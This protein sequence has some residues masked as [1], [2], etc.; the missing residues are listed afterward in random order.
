MSIDVPSAYGYPD[1]ALYEEG[2]PGSTHLR[3]VARQ[4][5]DRL[6]GR[7]E[8]SMLY[9]M[10]WPNSSSSSD[11]ADERP[12]RGFG[13]Q[14]W[15]KIIGPID[16]PKK[17]DLIRA[18][19]QVVLRITVD[20]VFDFG[21]QTIATGFDRSV[22]VGATP[23][24][25]NVVRLTGTGG[26][27]GLVQAELNDI[28]VQRAAGERIAFWLRGGMTARTMTIGYGLASGTVTRRDGN[29]IYASGMSWTSAIPGDGHYV[30]FNSIPN[31]YPII[32]VD[33]SG[34]AIYIAPLPAIVADYY[35]F[36]GQTFTIYQ[37]GAWQLASIS[38]YG[39]GRVR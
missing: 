13:W 3:R 9:G 37:R 1:N 26:G 34:Q 12:M 24:P 15:T 4:N 23:Q 28:P 31:Q 35:S 18:M 36:V 30:V 27:N 39:R 25:P 11:W 33:T 8:S 29:K 17:P 7:G 2:D 19:A 22:V 10:A 38:M 20:D 16:V 5:H 32:D 21:V 6:V 14:S